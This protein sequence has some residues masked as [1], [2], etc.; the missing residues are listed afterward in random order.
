MRN[1]LMTGWLNNPTFVSQMTLA[2]LNDIGYT[3]IP[4]PSTGLLA[5]FGL[6]AFYRH[7]R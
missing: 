3:T 6:L 5:V 4:E 7:R 2:S 1:E